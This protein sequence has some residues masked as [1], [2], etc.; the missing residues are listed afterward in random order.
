VTLPV[1]EGVFGPLFGWELVRL[2][3]R[4]HAARARGILT[5][6]IL[7]SLLLF[8]A[9]WFARQGLGAVLFGTA[10][11]PSAHDTARFGEAFAT[12]FLIAQLF[13][14]ILITPAYAAGGIAEEKDRKTFDFLLATSLSNREIVLG[15]F[16]ARVTFLL[17]VMAAGLPIL[18]LTL[19]YGGVDI[20]L[21]LASY[22]LTAG[23]VAVVG[24][25]SLSAALS[26]DGYRSAMFRAY[27]LTVLFAVVGFGC[28]YVSPL[29]V[30]VSLQS[31]RSDPVPFLAVA[32]GY[33][34]VELAIAGVLVGLAVR[35]LRTVARPGRADRP[36]RRRPVAKPVS[37]TADAELLS[38][39]P[40]K[41]LP[42]AR[43]VRR[44][45]DPESDDEFVPVTKPLPPLG[46]GDPFAW[47][48]THS[49]LHGRTEDEDSLVGLKISM[50]IM[51][52]I[53]LA[54][55]ATVGVAT[56]LA[57]KGGDTLVAVA[58]IGLILQVIVV[59]S[60]AC[61]RIA[62][63]RS[64]GTLETLLMLP[65]ERYL[66]LLAKIGVTIK[67]SRW[68]SLIPAAGLATGFFASE[69]ALV[70]FPLAAFAVLLGPAGAVWGLYLS[71]RSPTT[72]RALIAFLPIAVTAAFAPALIYVAFDRSTVWPAFIAAVVGTGTLV[73]AT[74]F[75]GRALVRGFER[76]GGL[77]V[78]S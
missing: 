41:P 22:A 40:P 50:M 56:A 59:G 29:F 10:T 18:C 34:L 4:G 65:G 70:A 46:E 47:K 78:G 8:T 24:A 27:G 49:S 43:P 67:K 12:T 71:M 15:K 76:D 36:P 68:W 55:L 58:T 44:R 23:T 20:G 1:R 48:E 45:V 5:A 42:V 77:S 11:A 54:V 73:T 63:E 19:L 60:D 61:G 31:L 9:A 74:A 51:G 52:G 25:A 26:A 14:M 62:L 30:F 35:N 37:T 21:L 39:D 2:A 38:T 3:R 53:G 17:A 75:V 28:F 72:T 69:L 64:R 57:G 32:I 33:P 7:L 13:A 6:V 16:F 66:I